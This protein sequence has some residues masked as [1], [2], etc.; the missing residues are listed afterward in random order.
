MDPL[1]FIELIERYQAG[2]ASATEKAL[3]E[4]WYHHQGDKGSP[5]DDNI[6]YNAVQLRIWDQ[7]AKQPA[8]KPERKSYPL[9]QKLGITAAI[10]IIIS[11]AGF[12][13]YNAHYSGKN[14]SLENTRYAN[15]IAPGKNIATLILANGK[16]INLSEIKTGLVIGNDNLTY[17]D[18]S[19]V[20]DHHPELTSK[21]RTKKAT[22]LKASTPRGGTYQITLPDGTK[23]WLNADSKLEFLSSFEH[24]TQRIVKLNGEAYFEVTKNKNRPFIVESNAQTVK[25]LGTHFN[26]SAYKGEVTKTTLTEGSIA[27]TSNPANT[28]A[29]GEHS[30]IYHSTVLKPNEQSIITSDNQ[31]TVKKVDV[32]SAVAWKNGN[33]VFQDEK[34]EVVMNILS[35]WYNI[36]VEYRGNM[37]TDRFSGNVSRNKNISQILNALESTKLV[38]FKIEG[39][40]VIVTQ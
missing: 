3:L 13:F 18:G 12:F 29:T 35:R 1:K 22:I 19:N 21:S 6:D 17:N 10:T 33:L 26:I 40:K 16:T 7:L 37:P 20:A 14:H 31:L 39:R 30:N 15:D 9:W 8:F 38:H 28:K 27:V 36:E 23:V 24:Q 11:A 25:V 32:T 34:I 4:S 2:K 5:I